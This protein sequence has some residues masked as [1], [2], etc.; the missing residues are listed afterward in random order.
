MSRAVGGIALLAGA[1]YGLT[2]APGIQVWDSAELAAAAFRLGPSHPPGQPLHSLL[3]KLATLLPCGPIAFR[4][5]ILSAVAAALAVFLTGRVAAAWAERT[6]GSPLAGPLAAIAMAC[7]GPLVNQATRTEVYAPAVAL[8]L[9]AALL[10]TRALLDEREQQRALLP[11]GLA[12][13]LAATLHPAS[14]LSAGIA[15]LAAVFLLRPRL[16]AR[17]QVWVGLLVT[18]AL[19]LAPLALIALRCRGDLE[20][21]WESDMTPRTFLRYVTGASYRRN[22]QTGDAAWTTVQAAAQYTVLRAGLVGPLLALVAG[23]LVVVRRS[24][25]RRVLAIAVG[26]VLPLAFVVVQPFHPDN[27]DTQGYLLPALA[28]LFVAAPTAASSI[29]HESRALGVALAVAATA[30]AIA[31][32]DVWASLRSHA[33]LPGDAAQR[34]LAEP[35]PKSLVVAGSDAVY[36]PMQYGQLVEQQRPDVAVMALGLASTRRQWKDA[37]RRRPEVAL[38]RV[39]PRGPGDA[40]LRYARAALSL[41]EGTIPRSVEDPLLAI[42]HARST[43]VLFELAPEPSAPAPFPPALSRELG[44]RQRLYEDGTDSMIRLMRLRR[45][46][47]HEARGELAAAVQELV[48]GLWEDRAALE[49]RLAGFSPRQ[50]ARLGPLTPLLDEAWV[51]DAGA[52]RAALARVLYRGG[53]TDLAVE[54][55]ERDFRAGREQAA[56]VLAEVEL[57]EGRV[58]QA[59]ALYRTFARAHPERRGYALVGLALVR[60]ARGDRAGADRAIARIERGGDDVLDSWARDV[61]RVVIP[62]LTGSGPR[63]P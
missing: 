8:F 28:L 42:E 35:R 9:L 32:G 46:L 20:P 50:P 21:C 31:L 49:R 19:G 37:A 52:L 5:N 62:A 60:A 51:T 58:D 18:V 40:A 24:D 43:G 56:L 14:G 27:P 1:A 29:R 15:G 61:S 6:N 25:A 36:F 23:V 17:P 2:A 55:L 45:A 57:R 7:C 47:V 34:A 12:V 30:G 10:L 26:V 4:T 16:L 41:V 53:R 38:D 54:I 3:G 13:G 33:Y 11:A 48:A 63:Q 59:E 22:L 39:T 44:R